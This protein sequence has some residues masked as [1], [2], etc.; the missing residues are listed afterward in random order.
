M[1]SIA[2]ATIGFSDRTAG[3]LAIAKCPQGSSTR[4]KRLRWSARIKN[5]NKSHKKLKSKTHRQLGSKQIDADRRRDRSI[6][7]PSTFYS[8]LL[9]PSSVPPKCPISM[10]TVPKKVSHLP[11]FKLPLLRRFLTD[12]LHLGGVGKL[13]SSSFSWYNL[14]SR[15]SYSKNSPAVSN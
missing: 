2:M 1:A 9:G 11:S 12:C 10:V 14:F 7:A 5:K 15:K 13:K 3:W 4:S 6:A 8:P